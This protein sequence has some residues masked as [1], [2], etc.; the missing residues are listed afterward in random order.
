MFKTE[1]RR[2]YLNNEILLDVIQGNKILLNYLAKTRNNII[3][4][5]RNHYDLQQHKI[6][7]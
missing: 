4:L 5:K 6:K 3:Y 2:N 7:K 1:K